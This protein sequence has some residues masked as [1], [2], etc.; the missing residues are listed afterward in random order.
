MILRDPGGWFSQAASA[1]WQTFAGTQLQQASL[2]HSGE[3]L[4][5]LSDA[6]GAA[7]PRFE[8]QIWHQFC[9]TL[10]SSSLLGAQLT[11]L[12]THNE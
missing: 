5:G 6:Q 7:S 9:V 10:H 2:K 3:E 4:G 12:K 11:S 1:V 8:P